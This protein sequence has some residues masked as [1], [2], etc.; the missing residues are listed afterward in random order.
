MKRQKVRIG[1][2][3]GQIGIVATIKKDFKRNK[4]LYL[5]LLPFVLWY[6]IF[7][8]KPMGGLTVAFKKY[9]NPW[10]SPENC[11]WIGFYNFVK[12]FQSPYFWRTLK[13]TL[14]I[15]ITSIVLGFP[16]PIILALLFNEL[17]SKRFKVFTQ[18]VSYIPHFISVVVV[19][20]MVTMF[21][22][23]SSGIVNLIL[24]KFGID[25]QYFLINKNYFVPIFVLMGIWQGTGFG[26]IIYASALTGVDS[27]LYDACKIDGGGRWRQLFTVTLPAIM[28]TIIVMLIM[29]V[30]GILNVGYEAIILLQQPATYETSDVISTYV[31]RSGLIQGDYS[32][33]TAVGLLNSVVGFILVIG[34]NWLSKRT[35]EQGLW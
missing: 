22:S 15:S 35:T 7:V 34:T 29:R 13:N 14:I 17:R 32:Y 2:L 20:S 4:Q 8:F 11:P 6:I 3:N 10:V 26:S 25:R 23:P 12:Y 30:G 1:G 18:T 31:Y 28:P 16:A 9:D 33:S 19:C 27:E 5:M 21:L 24:E